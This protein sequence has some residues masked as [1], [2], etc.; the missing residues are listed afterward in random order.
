V[1]RGTLLHSFGRGP[2]QV[3]LRYLPSA[4]TPHC[5]PLCSLHGV[6]DDAKDKPFELE[7]GWICEASGWKYASVPKEV[8]E[9]A[10][11]WAKRKIEEE[12]MGEDEDDDE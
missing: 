11:G 5:A 3:T 12:E 1:L 8:K 2:E 4:L 7:L 6:H 9:A 10:E